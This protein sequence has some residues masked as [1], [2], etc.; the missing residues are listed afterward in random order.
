LTSP[1]H[2]ATPLPQGE[3]KTSKVMNSPLL[4]VGEGDRGMRSKRKK[5]KTP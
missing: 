5:E 2:S 1:R 4:L 3:G